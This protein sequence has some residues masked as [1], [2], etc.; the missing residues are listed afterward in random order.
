MTNELRAKFEEWRDSLPEKHWAR[1]DLSAC[2]LGWNAGR[3]SRDAEV[4]A[5]KRDA[6]RYRW[7][8]GDSEMDDEELLKRFH[9]FNGC[10]PSSLDEAIDAAMAQCG[11]KKDDDAL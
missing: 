9:V 8:R 5:L 2:K 1:Y 7:L 4:E 3:A 10:D 6:D 11:E